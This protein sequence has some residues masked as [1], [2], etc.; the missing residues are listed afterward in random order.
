[1]KFTINL[2]SFP[3]E[4]Y[5]T[6]REHLQ[7]IVHKPSSDVLYKDIEASLRKLFVIS[8]DY[9]FALVNCSQKAT[10]LENFYSVKIKDD[11]K[12]GIDLFAEAYAASSEFD[13]LDL[14]YSFPQVND[15]IMQYDSILMDLSI[16]LGIP[17]N[18]LAYFYRNQKFHHDNYFQT[19]S[20]PSE[21]DLHLIS[22]VLNDL[23]IKGMDQLIRESNYKSAV[24]YQCF[25]SNPNFKIVTSKEKRS[26]TMI[27]V[28]TSIDMIERINQLGY[29]ISHVMLADRERITLANY[30][31]HSKELIEMF[32]DR[33]AEI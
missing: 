16:S 1:M 12:T 4:P 9:S 24:L 30:A 3:A 25:D 20:D 27:V 15:G 6:V 29:D 8:Q 2:K 33:V 23:K 13:V 7:K 22:S 32:A 28:D 19:D 14:S 21:N 26:R 18:H 10:F 31:T 17:G 5:F 11:P